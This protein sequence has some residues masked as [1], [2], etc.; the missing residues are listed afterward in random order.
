MGE[1]REELRQSVNHAYYDQPQGSRRRMVAE[2][3]HRTPREAGTGVHTVDEQSQA[4]R[5]YFAH[6]LHDY[7]AETYRAYVTGEEMY[8]D[9]L[10]EYTL[11][12]THTAPFSAQAAY[13]F[14]DV[15]VRQHDWGA[16]ELLRVPS[17]YGDTFAVYV[18]TDG[19]DGWLEVYDA[20]GK[21]V[22]AGRTYMD[23][24]YW[25]SLDDARQQTCTRRLPPNLNTSRSL[26]GKSLDNG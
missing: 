21:L 20:T 8:A 22:G 24:V 3:S 1:A 14:Y 19:D 4:L 9:F 13:R 18:T 12:A 6:L 5:Q 25:M 16:V 15:Q 23:L 7:W 17:A 11:V 10:E 2:W 26:W